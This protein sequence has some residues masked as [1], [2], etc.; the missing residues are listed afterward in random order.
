MKK[1]LFISIYILLACLFFCLGQQA[2]AAESSKKPADKV[3]IYMIDNLSLNDI[4]SPNTPYLWSL[5]NQGG[6]RLA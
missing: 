4:T 5:Q 2:I 6:N 3:I 1:T